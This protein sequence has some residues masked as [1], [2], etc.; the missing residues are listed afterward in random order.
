MYLGAV[1]ML[2]RQLLIT[3]Y[4]SCFL[5]ACGL[6]QTNNPVTLGFTHFM[7]PSPRSMQLAS[8][9]GLWWAVLG[10]ITGQPT[11]PKNYLAVQEISVN[12]VR[13]YWHG[14]SQ[15]FSGG[16]TFLRRKS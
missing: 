8:Y 15:L 6:R 1:D 7:P 2:H 13:S 16:C 14:C 3:C 12:R 5:Y 10:S 11:P 4:F 9:I